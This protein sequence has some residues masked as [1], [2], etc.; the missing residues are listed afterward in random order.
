[1]AEERRDNELVLPLGTH[2][3]VLDTNQGRL[4]TCTGPQKITIAGTE[5]TVV[6]D[7]NAPSRFRE[8]TPSQAIQ[9][10]KVVPKGSYAIL[11]HPHRDLAFPKEGKPDELQAGS[12]EIGKIVNLPGPKAFALWPGQEVEI[13]GG[14]HL[15]TNEYLVV[16]VYDEEEARKN[17][18]KGT[19]KV[20]STKPTDQASGELPQVALPAIPAIGTFLE[21]DPNTLVIGQMLLIMGNVVSFYIPPTGVEVLKDETT[22]FVRQALTLERLEYCLLVDEDGNKRYVRGPE[23]VFPEPTETFKLNDD[24]DRKSRAYEL[25]EISGIH[26]KV[27]A[28]YVKPAPPGVGK[29]LLEEAGFHVVLVDGKPASVTNQEGEELFITGKV[30]AI[31]FPCIEQAILT[32]GSKGQKRSRH[33]AVA[34]P[35]GDA[36]YVMNRLIG[37]IKTVRSDDTGMLLPDPRTQVIV[38]RILSEAECARYYPGNANVLAYNRMLREKNSD[39]E[40]AALMNLSNAPAAIRTGHLQPDA[41]RG[42]MYASTMSRAGDVIDR[43]QTYTP[44]RTLVIDSKFEGTPKI[45][46]WTGHAVQLVNAKGTRVVVVG[47]QTVN[48]DFDQRLEAL[49]LSTH[50]PKQHDKLMETSYLKIVN[51]VSDEFDVMTKDLVPIKIRLKYLIRF[52]ESNKERWFNVDNYVQLLVD[53]FRSTVS[54][55]ARK[56]TAP[57][58]YLDAASILQNWVLGVENEQHVRPLH[59]FAENGMT[60]YDIEVVSVAIGDPTIATAMKK[61]QTE[62]LQAQFTVAQLETERDLTQKRE[63]TTREIE[64]EKFTTVDHKNAIAI[65]TVEIEHAKQQKSAE[66]LVL[67]ETYKFGENKKLADIRL[68]IATVETDIETK[69]F[70]PDK[71]KEIHELDLKCRELVEEAKAMETKSKAIQPGLIEAFV[72]LAQSGAYEVAARHLGNLAVIQDMSITGVAKQIFAG[73]PFEKTLENLG[74]LGKGKLIE[75]PIA[76]S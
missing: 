27:I 72:A 38:Q 34:I 30:Q 67:R 42:A 10:N 45:S 47:P 76:A 44:P 26:L 73:T 49:F 63:V 52:D 46:P 40:L 64:T 22:K 4:Q 59:T 16:R 18:D 56:Q 31:Y 61:T 3:M 53:H 41:M 24:G 71:A 54:N 39:P 48:L 21:V 25:N 43:G 17:W 68:A 62:M 58:F 55:A 11:K 70:E 32:Y 74:K 60:V 29:E 57:E 65:K 12:L 66:L 50:T 69:Q 19:I 15:K 20:E 33:H 37:A 75:Q 5:K 35:P 8:V 7:L 1:M 14:H 2:A 51:N 13:V 36:R 28:D 6:F 23:V 9:V